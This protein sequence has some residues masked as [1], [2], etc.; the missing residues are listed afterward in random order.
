MSY[1]RK[2][3]VK[4]NAKL[5]YT[6]LIVLPKE[7]R[8]L[9]F[10]C[11]DKEFWIVNGTENLAYIKP[12]RRGSQSNLNLVTASGNIY[13]FHLTQVSERPE[14][15]PDFKVFVEPEEESMITAA[16]G[17]PRFVSSQAI[18]D[19]R[20]QIKLAKEETQQVKESAEAAID[21]GISQ[22]VSNMRFPYRF[23]AGKSR[24][25][26]ARCTPTTN[27]LTCRRYEKK[28]P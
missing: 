11:G 16:G 25:S 28:L 19:Y 7:E 8:I 15:L 9:D 27:S 12:A 13:S 17:A 4:L 18:D 23:E 5:R 26:C 6:M 14:I 3:I 21:R 24:S 1:G 10:T 22:F 20:Q 2:D